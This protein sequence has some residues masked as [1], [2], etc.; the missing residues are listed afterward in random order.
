MRVRL[1]IIVI[2]LITA[3]MMLVL[4]GCETVEKT[5][6]DITSGVTESP[7]TTSQEG[8]GAATQGITIEEYFNGRPVNFYRRVNSSTITGATGESPEATGIREFT[9]NEECTFCGAGSEINDT[10]LSINT[11]TL[12]TDTR[13]GGCL[14][15]NQMTWPQT[16]TIIEQTPTMLTARG[17]GGGSSEKSGTDCENYSFTFTTDETWYFTTEKL[18][19]DVTVTLT[20]NSPLEYIE[21]PGWKNPQSGLFYSDYGMT[22][23][24]DSEYGFHVALD[25]KTVKINGYDSEVSLQWKRDVIDDYTNYY[26]FASYW[27]AD[28]T[29]IGICRIYG[30]N[31]QFLGEVYTEGE[32]TIRVTGSPQGLL[33]ESYYR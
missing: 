13:S 33:P 27:D 11:A 19:E 10:I 23:K 4:T 3:L 29:V 17:Q 31:G 15:K 25:I 20:S 16:L 26:S 30:K 28:Y 14:T 2:S 8:Q 22:L 6:E 7:A 12:Y 5:F 9:V 24:A 1:L 18:E 21:A 32:V